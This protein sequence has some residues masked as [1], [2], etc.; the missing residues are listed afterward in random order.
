[1]LIIGNFLCQWGWWDYGMG[2]GMM[3]GWW[4]MGWIFMIFFWGLLIV[5]LIFLFR[6]LIGATKS[7][8]GEESAFDILKTLCPWRDQQRRI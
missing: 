6:Y 4:G 8:K 2:P 1:M 3:W 7:G 5:G